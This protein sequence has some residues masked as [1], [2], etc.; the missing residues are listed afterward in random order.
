MSTGY[1]YTQQGNGGN[2][3]GAAGDFDPNAYEIGQVAYQRD[4]NDIEADRARKE[5]PAGEHEF[6]VQ[7]FL[8]APEVKTKTTYYNGQQYSYNVPSVG[9]RLTMVNDPSATVIDFF[10]LPPADAYGQGLYIH[11][12]T[13]P[14]GKNAGFMAEKFGHFLSRLGFP[15]VK[16][17]PIPA[18]ACRLGAWI[19]RKVVATIEYQQTTEFN[20]ATQ[21]REPKVNVATGEPYPAR[22]QV[23]LFSYKVHGSTMGAPVIGAG[24][25]A[26]AANQP[27]HMP[28]TQGQPTGPAVPPPFPVSGQPQPVTPPA[29]APQ[30]ASKPAGGFDPSKLA[31]VL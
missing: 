15:L 6:V 28:P 13:K 25:P 26:G 24:V 31:S 8:K 19:G 11:G 7:G 27:G 18:E 9:V 3:N 23:K 20:H 1:D 29:P 16:G 22:A 21:K 14:D 5:P 12:S 10:E 30:A 4:A 17:Q 2:G